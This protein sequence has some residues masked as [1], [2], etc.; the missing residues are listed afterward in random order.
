MNVRTTLI[1]AACAALAGVALFWLNSRDIR[2]ETEETEIQ[3]ILHSLYTAEK[4]YAQENGGF[5][6]DFEIF[7]HLKGTHRPLLVGVLPDCENSNS[8]VVHLFLG[9]RHSN[10]EVQARKIMEQEFRG[11]CS[12][13]RSEFTGFAMQNL[14][15][16]DDLESWSINEKGETTLFVRD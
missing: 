7:N 4:E 13:L 16:D 15:E 6:G 3:N 9:P 5:S 11:K 14:D 12:H 10:F 8:S 2:F 1:I